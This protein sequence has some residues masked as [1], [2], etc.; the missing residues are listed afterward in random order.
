MRFLLLASGGVGTIALLLYVSWTMYDRYISNPPE[1]PAIAV[2]FQSD[3]YD[4]AVAIAQIAVAKA[5]TAETS[6]DWFEIS[7]QWQQAADLMS[8]I[9][10]GDSRYKDAQARIKSY[11]SNSEYARRKAESR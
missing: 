11:S 4:Q 9:P 3:P 2:S 6:A 8:V 1:Q 10:A 5:T 7:S